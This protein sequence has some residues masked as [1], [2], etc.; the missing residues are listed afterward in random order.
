MDKSYREWIHF[1]VLEES[2]INK[3]DGKVG[4]GWVR[5][6]TIA[7]VRCQGLNLRIVHQNEDDLEFFAEGVPIIIKYAKTF[8]GG[9]YADLH[10][11]TQIDASTADIAKLCPAISSV[12][13]ISW[14]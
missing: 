14:I 7:N 12:L 2:V 10:D 4:K 13:R 11:L 6:T 1:C 8:T 9:L 5:E 3:Q